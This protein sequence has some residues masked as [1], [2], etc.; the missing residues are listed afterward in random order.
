MSEASVI[1]TLVLNT[2]VQFRT[3]GAI[4]RV[5]LHNDSAYYLRVYFGADAPTDPNGGGWHETVGPGDHPLLWIVGASASAFSDRTNYIQSTPYAGVITVF[6]FLPVGALIAG[7]G[8]V[9]TGASLCFLTGYFPQ[10]YAAGG[11]QTEAYVQAAKQGRYQVVLGASNRIIG[12]IDQGTPNHTPVG[13]SIQLLSTTMPNLF[14]RNAKGVSSV[15]VYVFGFTITII[16]NNGTVPAIIDGF[17]NLE[18]RDSTLAIT[19]VS[20]EAYRFLA[21][22]TPRMFGGES[23][24]DIRADVGAA[25]FLVQLGLAQNQLVSTDRVIVCYH[26]QS[27]VGTWRGEVNAYI[28]IDSVN[29]TPNFAYP[30]P[31]NPGWATNNPQTY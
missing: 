1:Q 28:A 24:R 13:N 26:I 20:S 12:N 7:G 27:T 23:Q 18:I 9:V 2:P 8:G 11:N 30:F 16:E 21:R 31:A 29:Q 14:D 4:D 10:E 19:R 22:V 25:P 17:F 5:E 15:N 6:P 3:S